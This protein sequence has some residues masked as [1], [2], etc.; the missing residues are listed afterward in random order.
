[1]FSTGNTKISSPLGDEFALMWSHV[2]K[3]CTL[4]PLGNLTIIN[5]INN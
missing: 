1:M 2:L 5:D 4:V 3:Q